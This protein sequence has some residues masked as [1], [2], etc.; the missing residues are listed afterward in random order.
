MKRWLAVLTVVVALLGSW[1]ATAWASTIV[2]YAGQNGIEEFY[3]GGEEHTGY[4]SG[5]TDNH[6]NWMDDY[7]GNPYMGSNYQTTGGTLEKTWIWSGAGY[8]DDPRFEGN[9]T[10]ALCRASGSNNYPL[11]VI[12][13]EA[14]HN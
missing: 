13:C 7:G 8:L 2:Q 5:W 11:D 4:T 6:M 3:P 9:Y 12:L 1:A 10:R 14:T